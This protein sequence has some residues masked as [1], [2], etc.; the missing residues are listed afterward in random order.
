V[1]V[2]YGIQ[3]FSNKDVDWVLEEAEDFVL[4]IEELLA[5]KN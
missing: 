3:I 2:Q 4:R 1:I 5:E